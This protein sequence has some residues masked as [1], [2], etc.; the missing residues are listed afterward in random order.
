MAGA[1]RRRGGRTLAGHYPARAPTIPRGCGCG[2]T[3]IVVFTLALHNA[4]FTTYS[5]KSFELNLLG[6]DYAA[7]LL[8]CFTLLL[9][10][11]M[12]AFIYMYAPFLLL[13]NFRCVLLL[14]S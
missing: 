12:I 2:Y 13:F 9:Q 10:T 11:H 4:V 7:A 6:I 8:L 3:Q 14:Y 5:S 1:R